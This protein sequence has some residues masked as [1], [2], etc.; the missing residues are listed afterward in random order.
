LY[1]LPKFENL[2]MWVSTEMIGSADSILPGYRGAGVLEHWSVGVLE[3]WSA[4]VLDMIWIEVD[5]PRFRQSI[6]MII[7]AVKVIEI[8]KFR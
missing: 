1:Y 2:A 4:G 7:C 3:Y 6:Y 5:K 8:N